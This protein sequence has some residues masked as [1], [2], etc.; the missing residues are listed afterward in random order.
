MRREPLFSKEA[1]P[2]RL[3][4]VF[5]EGPANAELYQLQLRTRPVAAV[6]FLPATQSK[7]ENIE[8]GTNEYL[9]HT[10]HK[11]SV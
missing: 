11:S 8:R 4:C 9:M 6:Q 1:S 7:L 3:L 5:S 10:T 2:L